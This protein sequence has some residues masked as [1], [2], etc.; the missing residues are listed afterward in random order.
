MQAMSSQY[1]Y[2]SIEAGNHRA[3]MRYALEQARRA[4]KLST[5]FCVGAVL[6]DSGENR[7]LATGYTMELEGTTHAEQCCFMKLASKLYVE[8]DE[9]NKALPEFTV[10]YTTMEPCN[11]RL[12]GNLPCVDRILK[13]GNAIKTVYVGVMEPEKFVGQNTGRKRLMDAGIEFEPVDGLEEEI[14]PI[15]TAGHSK[16]VS[17]T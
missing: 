1:S 5:N 15:A 8:E 7:I 12:S 17:T 13:L 10:L 3:Y 4:P 14:V 16:E 9:L 2:P 11:K 6:V